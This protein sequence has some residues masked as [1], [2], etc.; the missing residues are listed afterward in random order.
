MSHT[1]SQKFLLSIAIFTVCVVAVVYAY[2]SH[3][4][5]VSIERSSA[6]RQTLASALNNQNHDQAFMQMY[7]AAAEGWKK[8]DKFFVKPDQVVA[9][10]EAV[11]SLGAGNGATTTISSIDADNLEGAAPGTQGSIRAHVE[12]QGSWNN[13][14]RVLQLAEVMPYSVAVSNVRLDT[15][16]TGSGSSV[17]SWHLGFDI[18][19]AMIAESAGEDS[20]ASTTDKI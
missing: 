13:V 9:F 2:M 17:R 15:S 3:M 5:T 10:I 19:A 11:E 18:A 16:S 4:T 20:T 12:V 6:A 7:Q 8:M 1:F 14:M